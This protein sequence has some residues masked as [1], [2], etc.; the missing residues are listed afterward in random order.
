[1][2]TTFTVSPRVKLVLDT[3]DADTP[4]MVYSKDEKYS[5]TY[6]CA[7]EVGILTGYK[8]DL[9]LSAG[10]MAALEGYV[11]LVDDA[12]EVARKDWKE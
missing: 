1:M 8:G 9:D 2:A 12:F 3:T 4:A 10:E 11:D 7:T 5:A 6:H